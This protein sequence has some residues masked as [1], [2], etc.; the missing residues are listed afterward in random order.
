MITSSHHHT[1][2][3]YRSQP[4]DGHDGVVRVAFGGYYATG[5]LLFDGRAILTAAHLFNG[6]N[7]NAQVTF[8]TR[9]G[10]QTLTSSKILK[11]PAHDTQ[12]NNDLALVWL[13]SAAPVAAE[14]YELYRNANEISQTF[15][16]VGYGRTGTGATGA[17]SSETANPIRLTAS[18]FFDAEAST[19]KNHLGSA[20]AWT[21]LAGSQLVAD[22]DDGS[23]THD[24]LG[25]LID[26]NDL[27][28]GWAEGLIAPGD[29]GGPAFLNDQVAGV[30]SYTTR[31][32]LGSVSPDIDSDSNSS[33]GEI[34][35]WQRVSH[36]QQWIDQSLRTNY[37]D[38][39]T[40]PEDVKLEV[41]EHNSGTSYA[42]F[43]LQFT[44]MR[45]DPNQ[46]LSVDY[47]TRNG[48]A[49]SGS[50]YIAVS[51]TLN[52]YPDENSAVIPV[53]VM[54]DT[55]PEPAETFYLDVFNPLGGSFGE[56]IVKLTA[57]RTIVDD[58]GW[59]A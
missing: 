17:T 48:T 22:F 38:A 11:H 15:T 20:M 12:S 52:L 45:S 4:G 33:F 56:G 49:T 18:N 50:D 47:A 16:M 44:G 34:A 10:T 40:Q 6:N 43:L 5:T 58:D 9:S 13:S 59:L 37:P 29:S 57:V 41:A 23:A 31:L 21:P 7:G 32:S 24:A 39:P 26:R 51:G 8:E 25:R 2:S 54:G 55:I 28:L 30:A 36:Y 35:S 46:I 19:L 14:R 53:E 3:R 42:Y 27:A 1:D